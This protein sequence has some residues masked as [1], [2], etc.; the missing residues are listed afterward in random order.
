MLVIAFAVSCGSGGKK[1]GSADNGIISISGAFALY[2]MTSKWAEEF[3]KQYP[4]IR[5]DI[6]AGGAG[7]GM[8]D[9]MAG[10]ADGRYPSPPAR[11]LYFVAQGTPEN[12]DLIREELTHLEN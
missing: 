6:S 8:T 4:K 12:P 1:P 11:P 10:I 5:I 2:P 9:A 3:Q 7:K